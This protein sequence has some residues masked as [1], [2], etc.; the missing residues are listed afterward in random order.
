MAKPTIFLDLD[1]VLVD[2]HRGFAD[3][4]GV[5]YPYTHERRASN[6]GPDPEFE[7][8]LMDQSRWEDPHGACTTK[9]FWT[10]LHPFPWTAALFAAAKKMG[11]VYICSNPGRGPF[12]SAAAAGK[13]SWCLR[14]LDIDPQRIIL[15]ADKHLLADP[16]RILVDD[17][18]NIISLWKHHRGSGL[19]FP[20]PYNRK[21]TITAKD[22]VKWFLDYF[23]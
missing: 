11:D 4:Y 22:P 1:G 20:Q 17:R 8:W 9:G 5:A 19:L 23:H 12:A 7:T 14:H 10:R 21:H 16:G 18:D 3:H 6:A 2:L 15:M 13:I